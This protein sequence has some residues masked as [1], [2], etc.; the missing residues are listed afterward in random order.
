MFFV[1][2]VQGDQKH[3]VHLALDLSVSAPTQKCHPPPMVLLTIGPAGRI[4]L[5]PLKRIAI[6]RILNRDGEEAGNIGNRR[7]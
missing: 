6:M 2:S 1:S 5:W 3:T 4:L 7:W